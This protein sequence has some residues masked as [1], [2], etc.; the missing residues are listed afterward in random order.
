MA[1]L[2]AKQ[3]R[4]VN[5]YLE[6]GDATA[7]ALKAGF[8]QKS[9]Q[10]T[11]WRLLN[12]TPEVMEAVASRQQ[13]AANRADVKLTEVLRE[14]ARVGMS[15]IGQVLDAKGHPL[16]VQEMPEDARRAISGLEIHETLGDERAT[17]DGLVVRPVKSRRVVVKQWD[18]VAAL[19]ALQAHCDPALRKVQLEGSDGG[20]LSI[21]IHKET[22]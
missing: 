9:A 1:R 20:P 12:R 18:K 17:D 6:L 3:Q 7:A 4:F 22:P 19:K 8:S 2:T 11:G 10:V 14:L 21:V 5:A 13:A 16:P 15:D